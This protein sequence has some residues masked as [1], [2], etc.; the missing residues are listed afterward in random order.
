MS[1]S[2]ARTRCVPISGL[3]RLPEGGHGLVL[4]FVSSGGRTGH[5][6]QQSQATR[7]V[8]E[9]EPV[10][11]VQLPHDLFRG[12]QLAAVV[13]N[14]LASA[15]AMARCKWQFAVIA[16]VDSVTGSSERIP[17]RSTARCAGLE[18]PSGVSFFSRDVDEIHQRG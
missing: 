13:S 4:V 17:E 7:A 18:C 11:L 1:W 9:E 5:P 6:A 16:R 12:S 3:E 2:S 15:A 8:I 10:R 14:C